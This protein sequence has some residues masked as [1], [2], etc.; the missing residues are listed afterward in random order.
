MKIKLNWLWS[1]LLVLPLVALACAPAPEKPAQLAEY[2][3]V[4]EYDFSGP[5][6]EIAKYWVNGDKTGN[7]Y[8]NENYGKKLG[9]K[10]V[11]K[12]FDSRYDPATVASK[13]PGLLATEKPIAFFGIGGSSVAAVM[14]RLPDDKVPQFNLACYGFLWARKMNW[15]VVPRATYPHEAFAFLDWLISKTPQKDLPIKFAGVFSDA[16]PAYV[17]MERYMGPVS[18]LDKYKGKLEYLGAAWVPLVP[19]DITDNIRPFIDKGVDLF[20]IMTN[21]PQTVATAKACQSLGKH[22]PIAVAPHIDL[23]IVAKTLTW[24]KMEGFRTY[25]GAASWLNYDTAAYKIWDKY[26][27]ADVTDVKAGWTGNTALTVWRGAAFGKIVE[28][29]VKKVGAANLTGEAIY[30]A[31]FDVNLSEK[32]NLGLLKCVR[33]TKDAPFPVL[34]CLGIQINEVKGGKYVLATPPGEWVPIPEIPMLKY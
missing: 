17:D 27:P 14:Q 6:A 8:W 22:V 32:D 3:I 21:V 18:A 16:S 29:A 25:F 26:H 9:V 19:V 2:N 10:L 28:A 23:E 11:L 20:I 4:C 1:L 34:E 5:Y 12:P 24:E 31:V 13:W 15:I 7:D 30:N 33:W